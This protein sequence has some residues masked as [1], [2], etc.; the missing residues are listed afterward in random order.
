M[1]ASTL[2]EKYGRFPPNRRAGTGL[3]R[4]LAAEFAAASLGE[5]QVFG[6]GGPLWPL[7]GASGAQPPDPLFVNA[8]TCARTFETDP[9]I[10]GASSHL[11][12]AAP[13]PRAGR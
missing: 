11:L 6:I 9:A 10:I 7:L 12:A 13:A 4:E 2:S 5:P 1:W 3:K 8:M